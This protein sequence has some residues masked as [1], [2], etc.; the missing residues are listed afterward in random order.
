[1]QG[2]DEPVP[3]EPT[4]RQRSIRMCTGHDSEQKLV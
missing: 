1:M 2:W 3:L 4:K